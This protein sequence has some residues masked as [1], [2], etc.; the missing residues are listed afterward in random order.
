[1]APTT[2]IHRPSLRDVLKEL[3]REMGIFG[4]CP[5]KEKLHD[6]ATVAAARWCLML[7]HCLVVYRGGWLDDEPR[8]D[9][10]EVVKLID[11]RKGPRKNQPHRLILGDQSMSEMTADARRV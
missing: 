1:M 11:E 6:I 9:L 7:K 8:C 4:H 5:G 3:H 10:H 2:R